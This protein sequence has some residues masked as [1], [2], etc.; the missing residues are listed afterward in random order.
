MA[1]KFEDK[2]FIV[3]E[4]KNCVVF[5]DG[6]SRAPVVRFATV[7]RAAELMFYLEDPLNFDTLAVVFNRSLS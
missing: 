4:R 6:M 7:T 2:C 3:R 5:R 1:A